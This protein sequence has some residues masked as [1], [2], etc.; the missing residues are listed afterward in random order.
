MSQQ[1]KRQNVNDDTIERCRSIIL[2]H[3]PA[4]RER[5][6]ALPITEL[7]I[8]ALSPIPTESNQITHNFNYKYDYNTNV[9]PNSAGVIMDPFG[10]P[11]A[12]NGMIP[13]PPPPFTTAPVQNLYI[14]PVNEPGRGQNY[15]QQQQP[16]QINQQAVNQQPYQVVEQP[17]P[18]VYVPPPLTARQQQ[19][20]DEYQNENRMDL[21]QQ[22]ISS[23]NQ[24]DN[25]QPPPPGSASASLIGIRLSDTEFLDMEN[26]LNETNRERSI[27]SYKK[28]ILVV[29]RI[30]QKHVKLAI[31]ARSMDQIYTF[32]SLI[33]NDIQSVV[34][35]LNRDGNLNLSN[36]INLCPILVRFTAG[37]TRIARIVRRDDTF[38]FAQYNTE[39]AVEQLNV[40]LVRRVQ[41]TVDLNINYMTEM[42]QLK[43]QFINLQNENKLNVSAK[44][45]L[46]E[47]ENTIVYNRVDFKYENDLSPV[48]NLTN[49]LKRF[50]LTLQQLSRYQQESEQRKNEIDQYKN[51][52]DQL[53]RATAASGAQENALYQ[54]QFNELNRK[55]DEKNSVFNEYKRQMDNIRTFLKEQN[56]TV[57]NPLYP[58]QNLIDNYRKAVINL[59]EIT[60][61][62]RRQTSSLQAQVA[63]LQEENEDLSQTNDTLE[64][65]RENLTRTL[66]ER[67]MTIKR[68]EEIIN[69]QNNVAKQTD[70]DYNQE[71]VSLNENLNKYKQNLIVLDEDRHQLKKLNENLNIDYKNL[72]SDLETAQTQSNQLKENNVRLNNTLI[73]R[74]TQIDT[75]QRQIKNE[76]TK[77]TAIESRLVE[78]QSQIDSLE[79][80]LKTTRVQLKELK[81]R[82]KYTVQ[83]PIIESSSV[84][85]TDD[86]I[87]MNAFVIEENGAHKIEEQLQN[88]IDRVKK[89]LTNILS[90]SSD[91]GFDFITLNNRIASKKLADYENLKEKYAQQKQV[92]LD[93]MTTIVKTAQQ[94]IE[95]RIQTINN[96]LVDVMDRQ[97]ENNTLMIQYQRDYENLARKKIENV[98]KSRT[99]KSDIVE[100]YIKLLKE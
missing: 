28:L 76:Q 12:N 20:R 82:N 69:N 87:P 53:R 100:K 23:I 86:D 55:L 57:D 35:C 72:Q 39:S 95:S 21:D 27:L 17:L 24:N 22:G 44:N 10:V 33:V 74:Q 91:I 70:I 77:S 49:L 73:E 96:Q 6:A 66:N 40:D 15:Q 65:S 47:L 3:R 75:L 60:E 63:E 79:T 94:E 92:T 89:S 61:S 64:K 25:N 4:L 42:E 93:N 46:I 68:L 41:E 32:D 62:N 48:K 84:T 98:P 36:N 78:K 13:P 90:D 11:H 97:E 83:E 81:T 56:I 38:T 2:L 18:Q 58:S 85:A 71:I 80:Q 14:N 7:I 29:K 88:D 37:Y 51:E 45:T 5:A 43:R 31:Y 16:S 30:I 19:D 54:S 59:R 8:E 52:L 50:E 67:A 9:R 99:Y 34:N 1:C 26:A